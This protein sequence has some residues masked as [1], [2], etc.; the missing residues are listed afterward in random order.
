MKRFL[1]IFV[2]C[3][4]IVVGVIGGVF[5]IK[6]LKGDFN[7]VIVNPENISFEFDEYDVVDDFFVTIT[8][9]TENVNATKVNLSFAKGT[10]TLPYGTD[11]WT[12][13]VIIIPRQVNIGVPF[14][15]KLAT[16]ADA[17][18]D[19][20]QWIKG[21][22]SNIVATSECV[23]TPQDTASIYV[24]VPVYKTELVV[25][26]GE[27]SI[28]TS[29]SYTN[30]LTYIEAQSGLVKESD[31]ALNA[32]DTFYVGLKYY[33]S[34]SAYKY[35]KISSS[36]LLIEYHDEILAKIEELGLT[37]E[38]AEKFD[39]LADIFAGEAAT[40]NIFVQDLIDTYLNIID[41]SKETN[42]TK[43]GQLT[44]YLAHL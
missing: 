4:G 9:T 18:T 31:K 22:I 37:S 34:R 44:Q 16:T 40:K 2:I 21:G 41:L 36:N 19:N 12:D 25:L 7:E 35:S 42:T 1:L 20:L 26:S 38:Y 23:T 24:D 8:T 3:F 43:V 6:Y 17:E 27:G 32:G 14:E 39:A 11:C 10:K 33:P 28:T 29:D 30:A 5:G 15:I 13:E